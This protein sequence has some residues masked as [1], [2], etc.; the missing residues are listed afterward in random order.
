MPLNP[1]FPTD[2]YVILDPSVRWYPG[3]EM[4]AEGATRGS[5]PP[6]GLQNTTRGQALA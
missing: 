2:P 3:E 5:M 1:H 6:F 4:L